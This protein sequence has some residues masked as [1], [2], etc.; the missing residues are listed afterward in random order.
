MLASVWPTDTTTPLSGELA[1]EV[2]AALQLRG[3]GHDAHHPPASG[4][5]DLGAGKVGRLGE[6]R[7]V[8]AA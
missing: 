6:G 8:V 1:H 2:K 5:V 4:I 7:R 3:Q